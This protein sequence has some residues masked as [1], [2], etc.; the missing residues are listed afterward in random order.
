MLIFSELTAPL[1]VVIAL[2]LSLVI[3]FNLFGPFLVFLHYC[4]RPASSPRY[5]PVH[6]GEEGNDSLKGITKMMANKEMTR[7]MKIKKLSFPHCSTPKPQLF[8]E[9]KSRHVKLFHV[10]Q[11]I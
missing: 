4:F 11:L 9:I 7:R 1:R 2:L 3:A 5:Y 6:V 10:E 8:S